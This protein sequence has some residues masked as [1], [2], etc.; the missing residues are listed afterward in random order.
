MARNTSPVAALISRLIPGIRF[1]WL[2]AI[3]AGLLAIDLV[4]PDPVPFIDEAILT[5]LTVLAASWRTGGNDERSPPIDITPVDEAHEAL[6]ETGLGSTD[7]NDARHS[8]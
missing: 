6:P 3:F 5:L 2:F 7:E 1:P 4:T 8:Q